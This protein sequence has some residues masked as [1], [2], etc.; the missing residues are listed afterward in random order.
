M[1]PAWSPDGTKIAFHSTRDDPNP[2]GCGTCNFEV[3]V[4]DANGSNQVRR[5]INVANDLGPDWSPD[6]TKIVWSSSRT[7]DGD[8]YVMNADGSGVTQL[9]TDPFAERGPAWS[10]DGTKIAFSRFYEPEFMADVDIFVMP[11]WD[12]AAVDLTNDLSAEDHNADWSPDGT[13]IAY[14]QR[15][16]QWDSDCVSHTS[17]LPNVNTI[18]ADGT[19][20][21]T[22]DA[23][24]GAPT[25]SPDGSRLAYSHFTCAYQGPFLVCSS[26]DVLTANPNGSG[27]TN[28][29][30]N[31]DGTFSGSPS[32]QP[33]PVSAY[34]RPRGASPLRLSLVPAFSQCTGP[35]R[36]HGAPLAFPSCSPPVGASSY[37]TT[38][39]A[40]ANGKPTTMQGYVNLR[41]IAGNPASGVDEADVALSASVSDVFN[42]DLTDYSGSLHVSLPLQVT[43]K[44]N[45]PSPGGPGAATGQPFDYGF[46]VPCTSTGDPTLGSDCATSTTADA[47]VPG[48]IKEEVRTVW[49]VGQVKVFDGGPDANG[50]TGIGNTPFATQGVFVP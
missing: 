8:I 34:P 42:L 48:T 39:T 24:G 35:N 5:T 9:T 44:L 47:L 16:Q 49:E 20:Q 33:I 26:A 10:P 18:R 17:N 46:D 32:W 4:M 41:T 22:I 21:T 2:S 45:T 6:G 27:R 14:E 12:G 15:C 36:S 25:W 28:L 37:L 38:G 19:Q 13:R 31:P 11:A 30:N 50:A 1:A 23:Y 3:Y 40:D 43:D 7:G 29:T